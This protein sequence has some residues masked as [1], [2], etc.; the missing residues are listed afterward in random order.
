MAVTSVGP[1]AF[2]KR[3]T[4]SPRLRILAAIPSIVS[5]SSADT[6]CLPWRAAVASCSSRRA[7]QASSRSCD[8]L[9]PH[10]GLASSK[11]A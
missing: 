6:T 5:S 4:R 1:P 7:F 11:V 2:R 3:E 9:P 10:F 8:P